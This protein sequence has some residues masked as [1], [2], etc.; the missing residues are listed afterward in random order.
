MQTHKLT[1]LQNYKL[2]N[3]QTYKL[4]NSQTFLRYIHKLT[5]LQTFQLSLGTFTNF[6]FTKLQTYKVGKRDSSAVEDLVFLQI[7]KISLIC[8]C[9]SGRSFCSGEK[10]LA[11]RNGCRL[12][13]WP[14]ET[15]TGWSGHRPKRS[16]AEA[17]R[18]KR[19]GWR[20]HRLKPTSISGSW[21]GSDSWP[22]IGNAQ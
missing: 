1:N 16:P 20:G 9:S 15:V 17:V 11:G 8:C 21:P 19:S 3:S 7:G 5:N 10:N 12:E 18:L 22:A 13:R 14:A 4:T 6:H 2:T